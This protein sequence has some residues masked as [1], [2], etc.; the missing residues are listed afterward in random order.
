MPGGR[1]YPSLCPVGPNVQILGEN[2]NI[3]PVHMDQIQDTEDNRRKSKTKKEHR[4]RLKTIVKWLKAEY[5]DYAAAGGVVPISQENIE[6]LFEDTNT[7]DFSLQWD[8]RGFHKGLS[9]CNKA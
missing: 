9:W 8:K 7:E 2:I 6:D 1:H 3:Q 4:N 5:P